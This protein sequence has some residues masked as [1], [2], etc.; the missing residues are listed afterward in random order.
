MNVIIVNCFDT[1]EHRVDL[2]CSFFTNRG[3]N[4]KVYT[5]NFRHFEKTERIDNKENYIYVKTN[6]YYRNISL[7]RLWSHY[8]LSKNIF[9]KLE[10]ESIDL[11]WVLIPPNSFTKDAAKYK[12]KHQKTKLIFDVI[13]MW[14]ET[15]PV[16]KF[17]N[18]PVIKTWKNLRNKW[19]D[20]ADCVVTE[21]DLY[22]E[23]LID[24][25]KESKMRTIYLAREISEYKGNPNLSKDIISLC[26]LGSINNIIDIPTIGNIIKELRMK[27]PII[28]HIIGD[29]ENRNKLIAVAE[30]A[31]AKVIYHGKVYNQFE[32]LKI[33]DS[34]HFGLNIMKESV[35]VG[36]TMKSIDYFEAGL[37]II[38]NIKGDTWRMVEEYGIGFNFN[39]KIPDNNFT[40]D[41]VRDFY[42]KI[43][44]VGNFEKKIEEVMDFENI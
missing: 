33:F 2:L 32:K 20:F 43:F 16:Y 31:G 35:F 22:Q 41:D 38:N 29:G 1:Y 17:E 13:D 27:K 4:V 11:L 24:Y 44:S 10:K 28:L 5:S 39:K 40:R 30:R 23:K 37:P 6:H 21:C 36:L 26:Y 3:D 14:P 9:K 19:I 12:K 8:K 42:E 18:L 25:V 15:M 7:K 34:C